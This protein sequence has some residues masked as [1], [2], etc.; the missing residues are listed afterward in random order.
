MR[1]RSTVEMA[2]VNLL[3]TSGEF[4]K[5][6]I[7]AGEKLVVVDFFAT[8]CTPCQMMVPKLKAIELEFPDVYFYKVNVD[9]N[10]TT[11]KQ[12]C[13]TAMP[14]FILFRNGSIV[15]QQKGADSVALRAL[16]VKHTNGPAG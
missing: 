10:D 13:V 14:T 2:A 12:Y 4:G 5:A 9:E 1:E 16:I 7:D 3:K 11:T 15:D 6:M 8:W